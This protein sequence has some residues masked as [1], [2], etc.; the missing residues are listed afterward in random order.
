MP[1]NPNQFSL[2]IHSQKARRNHKEKL[3]LIYFPG[4]NCQKKVS[5][6]K[7]KQ[8]FQRSLMTVVNALHGIYFLPKYYI[9]LANI[10]NLIRRD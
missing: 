9:F 1:L 8:L 4:Y 3:T 2:R 6:W 7:D 10:L 5:Q